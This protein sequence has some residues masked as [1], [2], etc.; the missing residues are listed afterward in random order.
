M[1]S[2][3]IDQ[4]C[5]L[6]KPLAT[7][8]TLL[9]LDSRAGLLVGV[10]VVVGAE[11]FKTDITGELVIRFVCQHVLIKA[12]FPSSLKLFPTDVTGQKGSVVL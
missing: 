6:R 11:I 7:E 8:G 4:N 10:E 9:L 1:K 3:V 5:F 12:P 2:L